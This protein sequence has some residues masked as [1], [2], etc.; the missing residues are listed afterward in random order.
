MTC[1][2]T[3]VVQFPLWAGVVVPVV[4][5]VAGSLYGFDLGRPVGPKARRWRAACGVAFLVPVWV[6]IEFS[7]RVIA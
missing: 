7:I 5:F 3:V 4:C 1:L 6:F 2:S